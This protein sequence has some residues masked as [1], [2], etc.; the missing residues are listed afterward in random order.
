MEGQMPGQDSSKDIDKL[1]LASANLKVSL[2]R[3]WK[4]FEQFLGE[5]DENTQ[6]IATRIA[7]EMKN[8]LKEPGFVEEDREDAVQ[9]VIVTLW[10]NLPRIRNL[11]EIL[12]R[13]SYEP[14][15]PQKALWKYLWKIIRS[16]ISKYRRRRKKEEKLKEQLKIFL[17]SKLHADHQ[18]AQLR[19]ERS[20]KMLTPYDKEEKL[21]EQLEI[22]LASKLHADHQTAERRV[23]RFMKM[24]T[25]YEKEVLC[26]LLEDCTYKDIANILVK[27][28]WA[29][30][31]CISRIRKKA[32]R[33]L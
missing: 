12:G 8:A 3:R 22:F 9:D 2:N 31:Q 20:M 11:Q 23:E 32:D 17:D 29:V 24:L 16:V 21:K 28:E 15:E 33:S 13:S 5:K 10:E 19:V 27:T 18:T 6:S 1:I 26:L 4:A 25:P 7:L 30:K 14:G